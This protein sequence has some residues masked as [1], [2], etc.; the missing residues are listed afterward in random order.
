MWPCPI[1]NNRIDLLRD[2]FLWAYKAFMCT[3]FDNSSDP[4]PDPFRMQCRNIIMDTITHIVKERLDKR[5]AVAVIK[6]KSV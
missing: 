5:K 6:M 1:K 3:I 2:V 4:E